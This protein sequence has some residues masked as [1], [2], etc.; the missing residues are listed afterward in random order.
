MN[1]KGVS[2]VALIITMIVIILLA[3]I[4]WQAG[5]SNVGQAQKSAFMKDLENLTTSLEKYNTQAVLRNNINGEY[6]EENLQWDG[7]SER[8]TGSAQMEKS[9]EEDTPGYIFDDQQN[10]SYVKDKI[11]IINGRLYVDKKYATE[12][13]WA[14][15][16]YKYMVSGD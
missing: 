16:Y 10:S 11:K 2:L 9:G 1:N 12:F 7:K 14:T 15:E 4:A 5:F 3:G 13:E 6:Y 8:T